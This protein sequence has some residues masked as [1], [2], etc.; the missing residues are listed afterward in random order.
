MTLPHG[1]VLGETKLVHAFVLYFLNI[2][3]NIIPIFT[4]VTFFQ[5][6]SFFQDIV[7]TGVVSAFYIYIC[8]CYNSRIPYPSS[9]NRP[10]VC[11]CNHSVALMPMISQFRL[12]APTK[13]WLG[14]LVSWFDSLCPRKGS[15]IL[16]HSAYGWTEMKRFEISA[17]NWASG[18]L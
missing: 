6:V 5:E 13:Q 16:I 12:W 11:K 7:P 4:P 15:I 9:L 1:S 17:R 8:A 10:K 14:L 18:I 3:F 2:Q